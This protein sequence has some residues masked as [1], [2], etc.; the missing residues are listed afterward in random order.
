[1]IKIIKKYL[2]NSNYFRLK[3]RKRYVNVQ[4]PRNFMNCSITNNNHFIADTNDSQKWDTLKFPLPKA[5]N[6][7]EIASYWSHIDDPTKKNVKL[8]DYYWF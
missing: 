7:W 8:V 4:I 3:K 6:K 5:K 2:L 1:M